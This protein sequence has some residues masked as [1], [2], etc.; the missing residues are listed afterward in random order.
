MDE[1]IQEIFKSV[2]LKA[3]NDSR[4]AVAL[5]DDG[6]IKFIPKEINM[7]EFPDVVRKICGEINE[8]HAARRRRLCGEGGGFRLN[9]DR[10]MVCKIVKTGEPVAKVLPDK[11]SYGMLSHRRAGL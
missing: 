9:C 11:N 8:A 6:R 1:V 2:S 7:V 4:I 3:E 10:E 5:L